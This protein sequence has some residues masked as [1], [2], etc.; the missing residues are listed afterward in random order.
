MLTTY[1]FCL[2]AG[3]LLIGASA[4]LGGKE[5]DVGGHGADAHAGDADGG[6][7][8]AHDAGHAT[9]WV[10][11]LSMQF[12]TFALAF[13]GLTGTVFTLLDLAPLVP[14]L[15]AALGLGLG[16][17]TAVS[18]TLRKLRTD[19]VSSGVAQ[20]DYV[21]RSGVVRLPISADSPGKVRVSVKEQ[22]IDLIATTDE[23]EPLKPG[24]EVLV[25]QM[26]EN[27]AQVVRAVRVETTSEEVA[28]E[29]SAGPH[30]ENEQS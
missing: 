7:A 1:L 3:G 16:S 26:N 30:S 18:Y 9:A 27:R 24:E 6:D 10:P 25:I 21:G 4:L 11:F 20:K 17:G 23:A 12:W 13:F 28:L 22:V 14:T 2:V 15:V 5:A 8:H 29:A 19:R